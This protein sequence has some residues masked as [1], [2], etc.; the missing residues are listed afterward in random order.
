M[1]QAFNLSQLA[2]NINTSGQLDATDGLFGITPI[3]NGGTGASTASSAFSNIKQNATDSITGVVELATSSEA[4]AGTSTNTVITP[5]T[6]RSGFNASGTAPVYACRAWV[7]FNGDGTIAIRTSGNV[8]SLVDNATGDYTVNFS[9]AMQDANYSATAMASNNNNFV[10]IDN[11]A[12][13]PTASSIRIQVTDGG[14]VG[15]NGE[16]VCLTIHR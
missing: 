11:E 6:M 13:A 16:Y 8:S 4:I 10:G 9:T 14:N 2:N 1:T 7:N 3:A 15:Q 5:S 12:Q